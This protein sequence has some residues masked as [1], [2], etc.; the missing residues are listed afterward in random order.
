MTHPV[1]VPRIN[2]NEDEVRLISV[3]VAAGDAVKSGQV[4][5]ECE[6]DKAT[7]VIETEREGFVLAVLATAGEAIGV[8][9]VLMW[10][11][12]T[13]D[14]EV[15]TDTLDQPGADDES[16]RDGP[17][18]GALVLIRDHGLLASDIPSAGKRLK[19]T[20]VEAFLT[21]RGAPAAQVAPVAQPSDGPGAEGDSVPFSAYGAAMLHSVSWHSTQAAPAYLEL[22]YEDTDWQTFAKSYRDEHGLLSSPL[23]PLMAY[24]LA[25]R[26]A[27]DPGLNSTVF[28]GQRHLYHNVNLGFTVHVN[29]KLFLPVIHGAE[30]MSQVEFVQAFA[31]RHRAAMRGKLQPADMKGATV[32]ISSMGRWQVRRHI[33][34]LPAHVSLIVAHSASEDGRSIL[35]ASYDHRVIDGAAAFETL[36]A[37]TAPDMKS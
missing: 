24:Q 27:G 32:A 13:P 12:E 15:P 30:C 22:A 8:G 33:P 11:G 37:L 34:I 10:I 5:A 7:V 4:L 35:G 19:V 29:G 16:Q 31:R 6:S 3:L 2:N 9:G 25:Q 26:A 36:N 23:V 21:T 14:A 18:A 28:N 1:H 20:D 17:T